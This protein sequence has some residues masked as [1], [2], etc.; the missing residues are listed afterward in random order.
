MAGGMATK[1][2]VCFGEGPN[3]NHETTAQEPVGRSTWRMRPYNVRSDGVQRT[4]VTATSSGVP[5]PPSPIL[6][7]PGRNHDK[8]GTGSGGHVRLLD[9]GRTANGKTNGQGVVGDCDVGTALTVCPNSTHAPGGGHPGHTDGPIP[10]ISI[11][12][13]QN[14][15]PRAKMENVVPETSIPLKTQRHVPAG[16][17]NGQQCGNKNQCM[18]RRGTE[19]RS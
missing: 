11:R 13:Q 19:R 3:T 10:H 2:D 18:S 6:V 8:H 12:S 9:N 17:S 1:T 5:D 7:A 14:K 16:A 15:G 4:G